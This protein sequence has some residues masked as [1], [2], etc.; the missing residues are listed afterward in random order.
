MIIDKSIFGLRF[1]SNAE[2]HPTQEELSDFLES[3]KKEGKRGLHGDDL[4]TYRELLKDVQL[5]EH[6]QLQDS[7]RQDVRGKMF[8]GV[9]SHSR[10]VNPPSNRRWSSTS[11]SCERS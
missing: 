9:L 4:S 10:I 1:R 8:Y 2:L 11:I 6:H 3:M 5:F 7:V